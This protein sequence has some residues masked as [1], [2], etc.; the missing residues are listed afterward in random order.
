[1]VLGPSVS[2]VEG[3]NV[4]GQDVLQKFHRLGAAYDESAHMG[5]IEEAGSLAGSQM[6]FYDTGRIHHRHIPAPKIDHLGP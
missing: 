3:F 5:D 4:I 1:M 6:L 2:G